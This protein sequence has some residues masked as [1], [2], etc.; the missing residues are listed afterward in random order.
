MDVDPA[1]ELTVQQ[2]TVIELGYVNPANNSD[3]LYRGYLDHQAV[4]TWTEY[5]K[6]SSFT[7]LRAAR[8]N[9]VNQHDSVD[10]AH[11]HLMKWMAKKTQKGYQVTRDVLRLT[12]DRPYH[13]VALSKATSVIPQIP[14]ATIVNASV[15]LPTHLQ[16]D[17]A[18]HGFGHRCY[19]L[20]T[21]R[22]V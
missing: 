17:T 14:A 10:E 20:K 8:F 18:R 21:G 9:E 22:F 16:P 11:A 13:H 6:R 7:P 15:S 1:D 4:T 19:D 5:G 3:K 12:C 2:Y